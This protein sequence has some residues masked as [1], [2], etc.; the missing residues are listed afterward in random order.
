MPL[1]TAMDLLTE[2]NNEAIRIVDCRWYLGK[3]G[4]GRDAYAAGHI[5]GAVHADLESDLSGPD[6]GG[7]HPLPPPETF[8]AALKRWDISTNSKVV[9]YDDRGG[10]VAAR[11]WWML[12]Q[13]GH[14]NTFVL[15]GGLH[16]WRAVGGELSTEVP[17]IAPGRSR[18]WLEIAEWTGTVDQ[19]A[20]ADRQEGVVLTDARGTD[21]YRGD[22]EPIDAKA[23]HIPGAISFPITNNL[24][25]KM[26]KRRSDLRS[27]F[28]EAGVGSDTAAIMYCGSGVK[29][30]HNILAME[31]AGLG[32]PDLY[33]GS[34]SDWSSSDR[35][36][37]I[38]S[39]PG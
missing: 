37:A 26:F 34:W 8:D 10:A 9:V 39:E 2:L 35:P 3:P 19:A 15:D 6:G 27:T 29:A 32:R 25:G 14:H 12:T 5:P 4:D 13:Q 28:S 23:G 38:G 31:V 30:C 20:V 33:V 16:V 24:D 18:S 22:T 17:A 7:R 1:I 36:I 21:R 11:L